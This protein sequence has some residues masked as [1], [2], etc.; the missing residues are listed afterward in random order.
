MQG[1]SF[2]HMLN[3][4]PPD[5]TRMRELVSA[6]FTPQRVERLR[7]RITEIAD[8]LLEQM[9]GR[10]EIDLV[11]DFAFPLAITVI[12]ELLGTPTDNQADLRAWPL[13]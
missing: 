11:E 4:D 6:G 5:H 8:D 13:H 2:T 9:A 10:D 3:S 1:D 7:P 12:C